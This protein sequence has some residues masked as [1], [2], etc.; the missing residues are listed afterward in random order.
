MEQLSLLLSTGVRLVC[1]VRATEGEVRR[2]TE[3]EMTKGVPEWFSVLDVNTLFG[4][5]DTYYFSTDGQKF[6]SIKKLM[7]W[8]ENLQFE[9]YDPYNEDKS[10]I[11]TF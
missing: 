4:H 6:S 5:N 7:K 10:D 1:T 8:R 11:V 9:T 2:P 3:S